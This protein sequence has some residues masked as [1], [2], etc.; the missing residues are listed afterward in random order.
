M[1]RRLDRRGARTSPW[2]PVSR[3]SR[4]VLH[5]NNK[6]DAELRPALAV[7]VGRI[8]VDSFDEID[9]LERLVPEA[10]LAADRRAASPCCSGSR[11][12]WRPTPTSTCGPAR[13]T[14]SSGS[15]W[16][17]A[18]PPR[19]WPGCAGWIGGDGR[20]GRDPRPHR[21]PD[22]RSG[23]LRAGDR[24]AGRVLRPA[25]TAASCASA[26]ASACR[27]SNGEEAPSIAEWAAALRA[28]LPPGRASRH[29]PG[30]GRAGPV[31]RGRRRHHPLHG[32]APSSTL[33]GIRTYVSVDGGMSDNPRPVLYGSGYEAFLPRPSAG[34][35]GR[36]AA[37]WWAS[38]A[39][40]GDVVVPDA[41]AA[42]RPGRRR[43]PGHAGDRRLRPLDGVQ[44][45]QGAPP[46]GGV[47]RRRRVRGSSS[48]GRPTT[49]CSGSTP[50]AGRRPPARR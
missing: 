7:G 33:P 4:L 36:S 23:V 34:A 38:T 29:G 42:R 11:R 44:L 2:P 18:P 19:P 16:P 17:R 22:L 1:P 25:R 32:R 21:Q 28:G 49:T 26:G 50:D 15:G 40:S 27:T 13:T 41:R 30:H 9:R 24:G 35:R 12:A 39:R 43:H 5:G 31:H 47:R 45:Q 20:A 46:A 10:R 14:P 37:R 48:A 3:P 8:V 6:S